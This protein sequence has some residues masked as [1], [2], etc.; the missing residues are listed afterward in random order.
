MPD[1]REKLPL[2]AQMLSE[3]VIELNISRRNVAIYPRGHPSVERSLNRAFDFLQKLFELRPEITLAV[4]KDTLVIDDYFL[5]RKNPV[6][7]EFALNLSRMNIAYVT[8]ISGLTKDELYEFHRHISGDVGKTGNLPHIKTGFIDYGAFSFDEGKTEQEP[9]GHIWERYVYGLLEGTLKSGDASDAIQEVPPEVLADLLNRVAADGLKEE[10]YD[11]VITSYL[12]K[13]SERTFSSAEMKRLM[14]FINGLRPDLKKQFLSSAVRNIPVED[15]QKSLRGVSV[16]EVIGLLKTINEQMV[17]IPA[18]LKNLLDEFSRLHTK[19]LDDLI[20]GK[21]LMADDIVL[22]PDVI[23][24]LEGGNFGAFVTDTYQKEIQKLLNIDVSGVAVEKLDELRRQCS[25]EN[26]E[27]DFNQTMLELLSSDVISEDE[28][29][30][31]INILKEQTAHFVE[32]GQYGL[33]LKTFISLES[34]AEDNRFS[35]MTSEA[36]QYFSSPEFI[37]L[38]IDSFRIMGR[39]MREDALQLCDY[40]GEKIVPSIMD[41]V[42]EEGSQ[43]VRRFLL[44]LIIHLG[45]KAVPEAIKHLADNRWYVKRNMLYILSECG[46]RDVVT[47][48]R[49]YCHHE[50]QRVSFEAIK[51]LLKR[52]DGYGVEALR[53][54]LRSGPKDLIEQAIAMTGAFRVRDL[55]P[56]LIQML[57]RKIISAADIY[58]KV[59]VVKALGEIGDTRALSTFRDILSTKSL[60]FKGTLEALKVE[61]YRSLK[62]F[63]Y[64]DIKDLIEAGMKSRNEQIRKESLG[65]RRHHIG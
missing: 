29:G 26:I 54:Y 31:F 15:M 37:S 23:S 1:E 55:V 36:L 6:Y 3:A 22:S 17:A 16:D 40:Y 7:R 45:D 10:T 32:T 51:C 63:P 41:A 42:I 33:V 5:D 49:A 27:R 50:N 9:V 60:L 4:A 19:G 43:T 11:R 14:D 12:R 52:G 13:S 65:L 47:H 20:Q 62:N 58:E 38:V 39:Q 18:T 8:F 57:G 64:E 25:D 30:H 53:G 28:Y 56:D 44:G 61:I 48:V 2:D 46:G 35:D 24:L 21:G 34:K 59:P